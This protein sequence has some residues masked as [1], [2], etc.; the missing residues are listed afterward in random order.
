MSATAPVRAADADAPAADPARW[1]MLARVCAAVVLALATWFSATAILPE[2]EAA[3]GIGS[4]TASWLAN[5][6][7]IGFVAGAVVA[8][9][10]N[11]PDIVRLERLMAASALLAAASNAALLLEPAPAGLVAARIA[12][13]VALA[14]VYPPAMKL[15]STWFREERGRAM[16]ALIGALTLGS[17]LPH[18]FRAL[19]AE[20]PW[21]A[22]VA[23]SSLSALAGAALFAW[24][25]REGPF[26]FARGVF[27]PRQIGAV[28]A[29]RPLRL[30]TFGYLG[31]MWELY[32]MWAWILVYA[33]IA[34]EGQGVSDPASA[35]LVAFLAVAA[36]APGCV[37]GGV[38][39]DRI[40]RTAATAGIMAVSGSCAL[41]VGFAAGGSA[42]VFVAVVLLWGL[43]IVADSAQFSTAVTELSDPRYVGTAL[44]LQVGLGFALTILAIWLVP[45]IAEALGSWRWSFLVLVPG[46]A[47]GILAMLR[48]RALPESG[49]LAG[50]RR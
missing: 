34:L 10:V 45:V 14:G 22:V 24:S 18:L 30:A 11:L 5:G 7:Q 28:L 26:P 4:A 43:T 19:A 42:A 32:A 47:L 37:L 33:R 44:S 38:L 46:P 12:T 40:G 17:A 49:R 48:L 2:M 27:D 31:H 20:L 3:L 8:S 39:S 15:V 36:G 6:V 50:G 41:A 1:R 35:S 13:G 25:V 16:G 29:N 21:Q 23:A 9:M